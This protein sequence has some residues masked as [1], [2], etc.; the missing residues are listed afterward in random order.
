MRLLDGLVFSV[1]RTPGYQSNGPGRIRLTTQNPQVASVAGNRMA[2]TCR[3][4]ASPVVRDLVRDQALSVDSNVAQAN[5][6]NPSTWRLQPRLNDCLATKRKSGR[7]HPYH[8]L[9]AEVENGS[10]VSRKLLVQPAPL[11]SLNGANI[12]VGKHFVKL[13]IERWSRPSNVRVHP[14]LMMETA[15]VGCHARLSDLRLAV[16]PSLCP[17]QQEM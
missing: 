9:C 10:G 3:N 6:F 5:I 2:R 14:R 17:S 4:P 12:H 16:S 15:A 1:T 7:R 11:E 8:V 13:Q